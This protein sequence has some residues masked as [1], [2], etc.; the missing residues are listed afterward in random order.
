MGANKAF[1]R[2]KSNRR[3][4]GREGG[5]GNGRVGGVRPD[6]L[7]EDEERVQGRGEEE[8]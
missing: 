1:G 5:L 2:E 7:R 3:E 4:S 8:E 6:K